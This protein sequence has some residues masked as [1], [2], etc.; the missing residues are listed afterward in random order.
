MLFPSGHRNHETVV[1]KEG[2][3]C[4]AKMETTYSAGITTKFQPV[5]FTVA[6]RRW[7][8][9]PWLKT[10]QDLNKHYSIV[11]PI[12]FNCISRGIQ[13]K[14]RNALKLNRK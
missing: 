9:H 12:C 10:V 2:L 11:R 7:T 13:P 5:V 8:A 14:V 6:T 4:A 1:V 3:E